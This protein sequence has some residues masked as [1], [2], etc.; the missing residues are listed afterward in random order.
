MCSRNIYSSKPCHI[1]WDL[2]CYQH[3]TGDKQPTGSKIWPLR[4]TCQRIWCCQFISSDFSVSLS[5]YSIEAVR[6]GQ[7]P[8]L[9]GW[10]HSC[11]EWTKGQQHCQKKGSLVTVEF[12]PRREVELPSQTLWNQQKEGSRLITRKEWPWSPLPECYDPTVR[13]GGWAKPEHSPGTPSRELGVPDQE[14]S[15]RFVHILQGYPD[16]ALE[17]RVLCFQGGHSELMLCCACCSMWQTQSL[18]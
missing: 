18:Q 3:L 16:S 12:G 7:A 13:E 1:G 9:S 8:G 5:N 4:I 14:S 11:W 15:L 17:T 10:W 2:N 6:P